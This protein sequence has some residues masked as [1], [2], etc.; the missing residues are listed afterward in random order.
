[1]KT[2]QELILD[3]MLALSPA[4]AD[5]MFRNP[6]IELADVTHTTFQLAEAMVNKYLENAL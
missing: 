6:D 5:V 3:F 4:T 2:R 1:M